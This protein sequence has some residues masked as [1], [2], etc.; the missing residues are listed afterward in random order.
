MNFDRARTLAAARVLRDFAAL[1]HQVIMFT[2]HEHIMRIF[3]EI[4]VEV[5]VLPTQGKPGEARVYVP[6]VPVE[7]KKIKVV[8]PQPA[9]VVIIEQ[10]K[11]E[12]V[13]VEQPVV[14]AP[15]IIETPV[16]PVPVQIV[17]V[18]KPEPPPAPAPS[19]DWLWYEDDIDPNDDE[20]FDMDARQ[21]H[22]D[23]H[24]VEDAIIDGWIESDVA[25]PSPDI[26]DNWRNRPISA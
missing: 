17:H 19:I 20:F 8:E 14:Q 13:I 7:P 1:G 4:G 2:C 12:P 6:E 11:P 16:A 26:E 18:V 21:K 25:P 5:R 15:V 10:P 23:A 3:Y 9:P 22:A 24:P